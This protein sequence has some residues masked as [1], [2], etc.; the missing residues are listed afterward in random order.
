MIA[1]NEPDQDEREC[2]GD[3]RPRKSPWSGLAEGVGCGFIILS[4]GIALAV[5]MW[6]ADGFP[7][8]KH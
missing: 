2:R 6:A 1:T 8:L 5:I 7:G 3:C 4:L